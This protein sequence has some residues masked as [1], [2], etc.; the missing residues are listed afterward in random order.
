MKSV[1]LRVNYG[2]HCFCLSLALL[3][4]KQHADFGPFVFSA[5]RFCFLSSLLLYVEENH[6][7]LTCSPIF[8]HYSTSFKNVETH[9]RGHKRED[10][11]CWSLDYFASISFRT[12]CLV[13]IHSYHTSDHRTILFENLI[14]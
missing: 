13:K 7:N 10:G 11:L 4:A 8:G 3:V 9:K 14:Q 1:G 12:N 6:P 5:F 2:G